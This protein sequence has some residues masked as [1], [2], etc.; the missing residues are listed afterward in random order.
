M[1]NN[2]DMSD[3]KTA[4]SDLPPHNSWVFDVEDFL[5]VAQH[6]RNEQRKDDQIR[7]RIQK[8]NEQEFPEISGNTES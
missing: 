3:T 4:Q 8:I 5:K 6:M 2:K 7:E 1:N